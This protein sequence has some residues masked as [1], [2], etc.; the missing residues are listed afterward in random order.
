MDSFAGKIAVIT[1]GGAGM[2][3]ELVSQLM[4]EGCHVATCDVSSANLAETAEL[5]REVALDGTRI[6]LHL[7]DVSDEEQV[8]A[9]RDEVQSEHTTDHVNLLFN[10]AGIGGAG[11][12]ITDSREAWET[13]FNICWGGVYIVSRAFVPMVVASEEGAIVNTSSINGVWASVG[14][15]VSHTSYSAAKFAVRGF[16]EALITDLRLNAPHVT[17]HVVMPGHIGTSIGMNSAAAHGGPDVARARKMMAERGVAADQM[18]DEEIEGLID[19]RNEKF[20]DEAPTTAAEAATTMIEA[21]RN[22]RWRVLVGEDAAAIDTLIRADPELAYEPE[23]M[24]HI[25]ESGHLGIFRTR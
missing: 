4:A 17:A 23:F 3:R 2:G 16:T 10:N 5:A 11:S 13:T 15:D 19:R 14:P 22:N 24:E 21:V 9:F 1:G 12:F 18:S 8:L 25:L 20:R 7:C 6:S